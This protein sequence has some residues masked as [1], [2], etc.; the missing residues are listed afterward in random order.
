MEGYL[1]FEQR[2]VGRG[3]I[4]ADEMDRIVKLQREQR[5]HFTRLVVE[6]G[7]V[8]EEDLLPVLSEHFSIPVVALKDFPVTPLPLEPLSDGADFFKSSRMVPLKIEGR[9]LL[10]AMT[11]PTDFARLHALEVATGLT[12]KPVLAREKEITA[13]IEAVFGNG[14]STDALSAGSGARDIDG[15]TDQEEVEHLRDM[16]SE[17]PVIRLVNA[18]LSRALESRASD[19]HIE[20]F[21]N[22]LKVR[23]RIDGIL[24]EIDAPPRQL[25]AA[26]ISRIKILA[27]LNIAERRLPQDGRIKVKIAGKDVDLRISTIPT[28]YGESVVIRL[29]ERSQ[30]FTDLESLGFPPDIYKTFSE[31][32]TKPHGMIL[33]TGP[34]GSGKSTTL[35]CALQK[36]NDP[37]KKIITIED[38]VEYQLNGVN[39]IHVKPLIGLTFAN[40]LRSI[41]RQDPDII[42]I[43]EIRD[44]ETAGIAI[45]AALTGHLVFSTLHTNDAAGAVSRLLEMGVEDYLLASALLGVLAQRLVRRLCTNCRAQV[46]FQ[47]SQIE[48]FSS[49]PPTTVWEPIGCDAC[50]GTGYLGRVGILELLPATPEIC[51]LIVQR[52]DANLI[53]GLATSQG[54][55]LL[56]EDGWQKVRNGVTTLAEVLRVT[57][58]DS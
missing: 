49:N 52:A 28:L 57:R 38:P 34:T 10:V 2:L 22:Q 42:M 30:I 44:A 36:I 41:V 23:Y 51:K 19:I 54:M 16:A 27:Q 56:R 46:P 55:R 58:E 43:G 5:A 24:H 48:E 15:A 20:P 8:S 32:I 35:Y 1:T 12:V 14:Y 6:L 53:R 45:Q 4:S 11:D 18:L 50:A 17:A 37:A 29:L 33:V 39:Q 13:R 9:D 7:F 21:E 40:G 47:S 31:M 25:K 3:M 26:V